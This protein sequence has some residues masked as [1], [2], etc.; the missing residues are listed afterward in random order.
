M[1]EGDQLVDSERTSL[2]RRRNRK[3][4]TPG[5]PIQWRATR[6]AALLGRGSENPLDDKTNVQ[7]G[8][9]LQSVRTSSTGCKRCTMN[10]VSKTPSAYG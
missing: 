6:S 7:T 1:G 3:A 4:Q 9:L 5:H 2:G 8:Y 10:S